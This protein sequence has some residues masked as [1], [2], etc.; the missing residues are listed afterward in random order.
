MI[1]HA[2]GH[3]RVG[4]IVVNPEAAT[5]QND[6]PAPPLVMDCSLEHGMQLTSE[7][8]KRDDDPGPSVPS[9]YP[10][11]S[12]RRRNTVSHLEAAAACGSDAPP[13]ED[14]GDKG[15]TTEGAEVDC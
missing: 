4:H 2:D 14:C 6:R 9:L 3:S 11:N 13:Q 8:L 5:S 15:T 7:S 12:R 10:H 1:R